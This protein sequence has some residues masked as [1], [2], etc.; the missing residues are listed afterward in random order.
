MASYS[1]QRN[2]ISGR[3]KKLAAHMPEK[4]IN[5]TAFEVYHQLTRENSKE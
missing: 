1:K 2:E 4:R 3:K 5:S